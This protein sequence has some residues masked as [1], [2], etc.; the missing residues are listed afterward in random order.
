MDLADWNRQGRVENERICRLFDRVIEQGGTMDEDPAADARSHAV[1]DAVLA[2]VVALNATGDWRAARRRFDP[3]HGPFIPHMERTA[4]GLGQVSILGPDEFL[5]R[6]GAWFERGALLHIVDGHVSTF[7]AVLGFGRSRNR[8]WVAI[9]TCEGVVVSEGWQG[10]VRHRMRW[11][12]GHATRPIA[13]EVSD[14]GD[15]LLASSD[16]GVWLWWDGAWSRL[17]PRADEPAEG[18]ELTHAALSPDGGFAAYGWKD[19]PGHFVDKLEGGRPR[20][21]GVVEAMASDPWAV[22]FD[23]DSQHLLSNSRVG[24]AG[25]TV[26][27]S[28]EQ[29]RGRGGGDARP[30]RM[31]VTDDYLPAHSLCTLPGALF[32]RDEQV[33]WICGQAWSH[34]VPI[35]GG[36]PVFSQFFGSALRGVDVDP[37]TGVA[38]VAS[39]SGMLHVLDLRSS[40]EPGQARGYKPRRELY[41]WLF[42]DTLNTPIRW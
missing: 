29:L 37:D 10:T 9:A 21:I 33:A 19:A 22:R 1:A 18:R 26:H 30:R 36:P 15:R 34:A 5:V 24:D 42:W 8:R 38:A 7:D 6:R 3:A 20:R 13:C 35:D 14:T 32:G 27:A 11:P 25:A 31:P 23:D 40:S 12:E 4:L 17:V 39:N 16:E 41:R 2:E 28:I